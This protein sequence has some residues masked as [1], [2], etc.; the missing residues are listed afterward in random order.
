MHD[1]FYY[2]NLDDASVNEVYRNENIIEA[3]T[4]SGLTVTLRPVSQ[5]RINAIRLSEAEKMRE[6]GYTVDHPTY[7]T[8]TAAGLEETFL[9]TEDT[10]DTDEEKEEWKNFNEH[11]GLLASRIEERVLKYI[12][13]QGVI[14]DEP[15]S[16]EED[17]KE[18]GIIVPKDRRARFLH[19]L[20]TEVLSTPAEIQAAAQIV[21]RLSLRG[22]SEEVVSA[23]EDSF[24]D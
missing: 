17:Q 14:V 2:L 5:F 13:L 6:E 23:V 21:T 4:I 20:Q 7:T 8:T 3:Q 24:R 18:D 1:L 12:L 15:E 9:H 10:L 16:W 11:Q 22:A 19:L